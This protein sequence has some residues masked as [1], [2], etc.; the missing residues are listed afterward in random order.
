LTTDPVHAV[1]LRVNAVGA[2][3]AL[4][5]HEP[6]NPTDTVAFVAMLPL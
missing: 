4:P 2:G 6:L 3:L 5:F 1:P